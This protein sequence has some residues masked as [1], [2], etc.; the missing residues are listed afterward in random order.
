MS[1]KTCV[2][3]VSGLPSQ[4]EELDVIPAVRRDRPCTIDVLPDGNMYSQLHLFPVGFYNSERLQKEGYI[5][6]Y[7]GFRSCQLLLYHCLGWPVCPCAVLRNS[8]LA[9]PQPVVQ[10]TPR[11]R[12]T[13][14]GGYVRA[15]EVV[16]MLMD[17]AVIVKGQ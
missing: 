2:V 3:A 13:D 5:C 1:T 10:V 9:V 14:R 12:T 7:S 15:F 11:R 16:L 17:A 8:G 6:S 4:T